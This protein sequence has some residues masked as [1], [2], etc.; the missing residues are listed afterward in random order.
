MIKMLA[1]SGDDNYFVISRYHM[2][3]QGKYEKF[4]DIF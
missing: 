4:A 2:N 3:P 1:Y